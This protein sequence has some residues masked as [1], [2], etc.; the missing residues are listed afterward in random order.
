MLYQNKLKL[1]IVIPLLCL[2][3]CNQYSVNTYYDEFRKGQACSLKNYLLKS[4]WGFF[5]G[6]RKVEL[7]L[8]Q[9]DNGKILAHFRFCAL[10]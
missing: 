1:S 3:G 10:I 2:A 8:D 6:S 4:E 5:G 9:S 7:N